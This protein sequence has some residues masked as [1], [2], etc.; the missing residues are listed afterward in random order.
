LPAE[1]P[2]PHAVAASAATRTTPIEE[3]RFMEDF[4]LVA[5]VVGG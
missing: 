5:A 1:L 2:E 3:T 4:L